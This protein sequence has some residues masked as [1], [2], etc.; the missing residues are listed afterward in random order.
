MGPE[1]TTHTKR[2]ARE[3][4]VGMYV[5]P[6]EPL[7]TQRACTCVRIRICACIVYTRTHARTHAHIRIH[8]C[9]HTCIHTHI[10]PYTCTHTHTHT[11]TN[12]HT[13][14]CTRTRTHTHTHT[15]TRA[16]SACERGDVAPAVVWCACGGRHGQQQA[17]RDRL[18]HLRLHSAGLQTN[19]L[20]C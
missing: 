13:H 6:S 7:R 18:L 9:T 8:T 17:Q 1:A 16:R 10:R 5:V 3:R 12:K 2:T 15:N 4:C 20:C 14:T 19:S 11:H